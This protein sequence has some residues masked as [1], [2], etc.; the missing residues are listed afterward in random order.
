MSATRQADIAWR[1]VVMERAKGICEWC[2]SPATEAHHHFGRKMAVRFRSESGVAL[3][4]PCHDYYHDVDRGPGK[5]KF[6]QQRPE[7]F[8]EMSRLKNT[9]AKLYDW[10]I[11]EIAAGLRAELRKVAA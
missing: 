8:E 6:Q 9:T 3:C 10:E 1:A 2:G 7:N 11:K 4:D 5:I